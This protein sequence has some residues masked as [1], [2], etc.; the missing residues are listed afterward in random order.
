M[1]V[2]AV[3]EGL[4]EALAL[5]LR[6]AVELTLAAGAATGMA[7][8]GLAGHYRAWAVDSLADAGRL[9]DKIVGLGGAPEPAV[10]EPRFDPDPE[11]MAR[12]LLAS[13]DEA[14][15]TLRQVI[16]PAGD[17]ARGEALEHLLEHLILRKQDQADFLRRALGES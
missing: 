13:E 10:A 8:V 17:E 6:G 16:K 15:E 1:D 14:T 7:Y 4:N 12:R 3:L 9:V 2:K 5:E 11:K